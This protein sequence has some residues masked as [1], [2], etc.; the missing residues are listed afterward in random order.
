MLHNTQLY[1]IKD[2]TK[3]LLIL[4]SQDIMKRKNCAIFMMK[5]AIACNINPVMALNTC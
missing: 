2:Q 1:K 5:Y 3:F 4:E